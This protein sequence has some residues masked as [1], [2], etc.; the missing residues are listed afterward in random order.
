ML[1]FPFFRSFFFKTHLSNFLGGILF[2]DLIWILNHSEKFRL[3]WASGHPSLVPELPKHSE[4]SY[5]SMLKSTHCSLPHQGIFPKK[6]TSCCP[7]WWENAWIFCISSDSNMFS[8]FWYQCPVNFR[9]CTGWQRVVTRCQGEDISAWMRLIIFSSKMLQK[10]CWEQQISK[11]VVVSTSP[12]SK[13]CWYVFDS[14]SLQP[15]SATSHCFNLFSYPA[16]LEVCMYHMSLSAA[17]PNLSWLNLGRFDAK[18]LN[19]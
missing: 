14:S 3:P 10:R 2:Q 9:G 17:H 18:K 19:M 16:K 8:H 12:T 6:C 5:L 1:R 4:P 7:T 13:V 11:Q 15:I